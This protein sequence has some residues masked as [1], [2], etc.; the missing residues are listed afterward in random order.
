MEWWQIVSVV[1]GSGVLVAVINLIMKRMERKDAVKDRKDDTAEQLEEL[2][3]ET[4][5]Q[6]I[7]V[8]GRFRSVEKKIDTVAGVMSAI[9]LSTKTQAYDRIRYMG[10]QYIK[11]GEISDEELRNLSEMH[12]AY[13]ALG[14]DGFLDKVMA[15]VYKL[16]IKP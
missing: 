12:E 2:R 10:M 16:R 6:F 3:A 7:Q 5:E 4:S 13:K 11:A 14:G 15:E 9:K 8:D 1:L